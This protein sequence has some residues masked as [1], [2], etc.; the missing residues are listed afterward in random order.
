MKIEFCL[1]YPRVHHLFRQVSSSSAIKKYVCHVKNCSV[2]DGRLEK[3]IKYAEGYN[4]YAE[5]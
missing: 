3:H 2:V 4:R 5:K 1:R